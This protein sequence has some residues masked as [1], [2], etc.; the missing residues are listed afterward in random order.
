MTALARRIPGAL[1]ES[2]PSPQKYGTTFTANAALLAVVSALLWLW[3]M[4]H[5]KPYVGTLIFSGVSLAG[6]GGVAAAVFFSF[7]DK[8]DAVGALRRPLHSPMFTRVLLASLPVIAFAYLTTFTVY[9]TASADA[10]EVRLNVKN[11]GSATDVRFTPAEKQKAVSYFFAFRPVT[12]RIETLAPSGFNALDLP[13][14]RGLQA[15]LT[16]PDLKSQKA[17]HVV[18]LMPLYGLF[19]LRGRRSPDMHYVVRVFVPG[20]RRPIERSG[21]SFSAIY[22]GAS[23]SDL[24]AQSKAQR[25]AIAGLRNTLS[26]IDGGMKAEEIDG[27]IADWLDHPEFIPTPELKE[28]DQVRVVV[29]SPAGRGETIVNVVAAV[30]DAFLKGAAE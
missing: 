20:V 18:R 17:F 14:R 7:V 5:V 23:L 4:A 13:L 10:G 6:W 30:N 28:G 16:V 24:Q 2:T 12:V 21:L 19:Q 15:E 11:R 1:A 29:E 3:F 9:L 27:I 22:L 8:G 26:G 25:A